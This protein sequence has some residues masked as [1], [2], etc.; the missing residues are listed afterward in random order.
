MKYK[1]N[2]SE[3]FNLGSAGLITNQL[4]LDTLGYYHSVL[5]NKRIR[6][7]SKE[8]QLASTIE[9]IKKELFKY[10]YRVDQF[11]WLRSMGVYMELRDELTSEEIFN[12]FFEYWSDILFEPKKDEGWFVFDSDVKLLYHFK[13]IIEL[14]KHRTL[15][16]KEWEEKVINFE[17]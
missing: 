9:I 1:F 7:N 17:L 5:M 11:E 10:S 15:T 6:K 8:Y 16:S 14:T 4:M 12:L 3:L 13:R 2:K